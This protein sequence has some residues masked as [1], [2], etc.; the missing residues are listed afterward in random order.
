M[1]IYSRVNPSGGTLIIY[2]YIYMYVYIYIYIAGLTPWLVA[3]RTRTGR[4]KAEGEMI[5]IYK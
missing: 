4:R 1:Y 2:V 3:I 5:Y